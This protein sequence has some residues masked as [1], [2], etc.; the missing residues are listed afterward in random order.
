MY[1]LIHLRFKLFKIH[2]FK[3]KMSSIS[4][5]TECNTQAEGPAYSTELAVKLISV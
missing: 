3:C 2:G 4:Q 5:S 1:T